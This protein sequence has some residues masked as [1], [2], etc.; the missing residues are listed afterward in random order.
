MSYSM[1]KTLSIPFEKALQ[2]VKE[3]LGSEGFGVLT[4]I[5]MRETLKKKLNVDYRQYTIL[6]ACN[7][8]FAY[9]A[10]QVEDRIGLL[11]PC[12]VVVQGTAD[13]RVEAAAIDPTIAMQT[14]G[15]P[16]LTGIA[17]Q[18]KEKLARVIAAL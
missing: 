18:V 15:N 13:G 2:R 1:Q 16:K 4:E 8:P 11:L 12:N 7:P 5:D 17:A 3:C 10:L 9:Q 14:V 6:G